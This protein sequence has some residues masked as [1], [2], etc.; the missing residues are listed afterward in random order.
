MAID[1]YYYMSTMITLE[2]LMP[3]LNGKK[4]LIREHFSE[5]KKRA[6]KLL[7][8]IRG[9]LGKEMI[10]YT[11]P[12]NVTYIRYTTRRMD[13]DN[14]CASFKTLG[15][16]LVALKILKDDD[17]DFIIEFIPRQIK[18]KTK[19]EEKTVVIIEPLE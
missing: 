17:P 10:K 11:E 19:K 3:G 5:K 15:D 12:V 6:N 1:W 18:V 4:G 8:L 14:H 7:W 9:Q 16:V 2:M 13:W